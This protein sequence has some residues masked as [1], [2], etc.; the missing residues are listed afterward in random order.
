MRMA[1]ENLKEVI[2]IRV[3]EKEKMIINDMAIRN[4]MNI[5]KLMRDLIFGSGL[6][7]TSNK[8]DLAKI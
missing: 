6:V 1:R 7:V 3:T 4:R 5:T 2:S 8:L